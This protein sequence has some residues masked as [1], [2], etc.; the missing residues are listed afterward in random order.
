M[1]I[2]H[3]MPT[4]ECT[5]VFELSV[6]QEKKYRRVKLAKDLILMPSI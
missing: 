4:D 6:M 1:L 5:P 2:F 3:S